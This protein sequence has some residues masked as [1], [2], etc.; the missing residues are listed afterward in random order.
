VRRGAWIGCLLLGVLVAG[1]EGLAR[2]RAL[3]DLAVR[4]RPPS[5]SAGFVHRGVSC[6]QGFAAPGRRLTA[7]Q[8]LALGAVPTGEEPIFVLRRGGPLGDELVR[9]STRAAPAPD[10]A[11]WLRLE[12]ELEVT[13]AEPL[14]LEV[15]PQPGAERTPLRLCL[16]P[17]GLVGTR[18]DGGRE[19]PPLNEH[20]RLVRADHD[21][22]SGLAVPLRLLPPGAGPVE[23]ALFAVAAGPAAAPFSAQPRAEDLEL[24]PPLADAPLV[25]VPWS[26]P[27]ALDAGHLLFRFA[28]LESSR[29]AHYWARLRV[30]SGARVQGDTGGFGVSLLHG[31]ATARQGLLGA[32]VGG[33]AQPDADLHLWV[34]TAD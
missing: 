4:D 7:V 9:G 28:P 33:V 30:P 29:G 31:E 21:R 13:P 19:L 15:E 14:F 20:W 12:L 11:T 8:L 17:R 5:L 3:P 26:E 34:W 2:W 22:L 18:V 16:R 1:V 10:G 6:G 23:L 27:P 32:V 25:D 24:D